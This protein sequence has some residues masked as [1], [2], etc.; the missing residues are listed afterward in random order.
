MKLVFLVMMFLESIIITRVV[1]IEPCSKLPAIDFSIRWNL[2]LNESNGVTRAQAFHKLRTSSCTR[3]RPAS[4]KSRICDL[5]IDSQEYIAKR[6]AQHDG[7]RWVRS[8][9]AVFLQC[10]L[11][12]SMSTLWFPKI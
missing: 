8:S 11:S 5:N 4:S 3:K 1:I 10:L 6:V 9:A 7:T 12:M 2:F